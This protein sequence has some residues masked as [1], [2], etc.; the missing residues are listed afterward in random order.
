VQ[1]LFEHVVRVGHAADVHPARGPEEAQEG[2]GDG[3]AE[4]GLQRQVAALL[5]ELD[6][7]CVGVPDARYGEELCACVILRDGAAATEPEIRG[8]CDGRI[9]RYKIP[10]YVR[11][12]TGFP[13]T[14]T[15]KVAKYRL[16]QQV[17]RD[18][19]AGADAVVEG[20]SSLT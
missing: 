18:L 16:R 11:F 5:T 15:G 4:L 19:A 6:V 9:A 17:A 14:V 10:R 2:D 12:M 7:Q 1:V 13:L 20:A 8:F 3:A